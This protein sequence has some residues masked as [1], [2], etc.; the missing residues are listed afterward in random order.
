GGTPAS[1]RRQSSLDQELLSARTTLGP[2]PPASAPTGPLVHGEVVG[3]L[4]GGKDPPP[5][6]SPGPARGCGDAVPGR[7][8]LTDDGQ[9]GAHALE[10]RARSRMAD[11]LSSAAGSISA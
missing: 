3:A 11:A 1:G 7:R 4:R 9:G 6:R 2:V 5:H 8:I 10:L